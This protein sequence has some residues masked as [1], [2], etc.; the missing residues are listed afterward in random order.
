MK[1][2]L[3]RLT[4][5]L[6]DLVTEHQCLQ[7]VLDSGRLSET[8]DAPLYVKARVDMPGKFEIADGHHR[9]A[10]ALRAGIRSLPADADAQPDDEPYQPPFFDFHAYDPEAEAHP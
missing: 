4:L 7:D 3:R 6:T 2:P 9:V 8:P 1:A 5:P 10:A